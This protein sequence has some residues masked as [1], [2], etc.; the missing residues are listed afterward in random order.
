M[1]LF[2]AL[3]AY[4]TRTLRDAAIELVVRTSGQPRELPPLLENVVF[5]VAQEAINN[6]ARHS[7]ANNCKLTLTGSATTLRVCIQDD[8][9]GFDPESIT[10]GHFGFGNMRERVE[11]IDGRL[12]VDSKPGRG[13]TVDVR[14][15][16]KRQAGATD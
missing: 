16:Y 2:A 9:L 14:V 3:Q 12:V 6:V 1:G 15:V 8:G 4:A 13:T 7:A 5:R 10:V 11:L